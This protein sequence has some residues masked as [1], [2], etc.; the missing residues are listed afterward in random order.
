MRKFIISF[1]T[2]LLLSSC[3]SSKPS[4]FYNVVAMKKFDVKTEKVMDLGI[5]P[6]TIPNYLTKQ[7][8]VTAKSNVEFNV[9]EINRWLEPLQ[10]SIQRIVAENLGH[11]LKKSTVKMTNF[12]KEKYNYTV[13]ID[14]HNFD[15]SFDGWATLTATYH[16]FK[17]NDIVFTNQINIKKDFVATKDD[18]DKLVIVYSELLDELSLDILKNVVK[19]SR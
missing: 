15:G 2:I 9:S 11:Y 8:I 14:I 13:Q 10:Y 18:Y 5:R 7:Q 17:S 16:I 12:E 4:K 1:F 3:S 19:I 6:V